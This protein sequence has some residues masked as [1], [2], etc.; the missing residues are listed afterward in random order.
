MI[1]RTELLLD[2][3]TP[4]EFETIMNTAAALAA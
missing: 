4:I 2:H 1:M 3:V